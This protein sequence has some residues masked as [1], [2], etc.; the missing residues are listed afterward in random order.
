MDS[1]F[2][3]IPDSRFWIPIV[4]GISDSLSCI[5]DSHALDSGFHNPNLSDSG[6][7]KQKILGFW[8]PSSLTTWGDTS[9]ASNL[10]IPLLW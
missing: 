3:A 10:S 6:F 7:Y 4:R 5:P 9:M 1:G 8:N 2:H